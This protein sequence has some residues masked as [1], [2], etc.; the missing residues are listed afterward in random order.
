MFKFSIRTE[1]LIESKQDGPISLPIMIDLLT[2]IDQSGNLVAAC[3][4]TGLSY[5]YGWGLLR[6]FEKEF[7]VALLI[8]S[9]R[10][11]TELTPF[12]KKLIWANKRIEARLGPT[13]EGLASE[14]GKEI[15]AAIAPPQPVL[16]LHASHGFAVEALIHRLQQSNHPIEFKYEETTQ[17]LNSLLQ[18]NCDVAGF[19][20]PI[21][22]LRHSV[23]K[24]Y[25][26]YL[27]AKDQKIVHLS[28]RTLGIIT[29]PGNPKNIQSIHDFMRGDVSMVNRQPSSGTRTLLDLILKSEKMDPQKIRGYGNSEFTHS[30]VAAYIASG[31]ADVG[32]GI[33]KSAQQFGLHFLPVATEDYYMIFHHTSEKNPAVQHMISIMQDAEFRQQIN[34]MAGYICER[35]ADVIDAAQELSPNP[36][37]IHQD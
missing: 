21:G 9:R 31:M 12:G 22:P 28:L 10:K 8:T 5:R 23:L 13:L 35:P 17:A 20:L 33:E 37:K 29:A 25:A 19:H 34:Q 3:K 15:E 18:G 16:Q 27:R 36:H 7:A 4:N 2:A 14:L 11:G 26:K 6:K 30:A 24:H 1:W 32:F